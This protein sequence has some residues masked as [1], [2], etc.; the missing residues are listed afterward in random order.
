MKK[1]KKRWIILSTAVTTLGLTAALPLGII[2]FTNSISQI[3][4]V[5]SI[6][7]DD[8]KE[9]IP[10]Q[11]ISQNSNLATKT[12]PLTF[13]GNKITALDWY[14]SKIWDIDMSLY[15]E[16]DNGKTG[17]EA[18]Y[19]KG[20]WQRAWL[21]WDYS[22][23]TDT[24]WIIG[25]GNNANANSK[26][27]L[28]SVNA[29]TGELKETVDLGVTGTVYYVSA[30]ASGNVMCYGTATTTYQ[31]T[32]FLYDVKAKEVRKI[33]GDSKQQADELKDENPSNPN[34]TFNKDYRWS[35]S[36]LIPVSNNVNFVEI[37][38]F[39]TKSSTDDNGAN[40]ASYD[41]YFIMVDDNLNSI[42]RPGWE[43]PKK[44]AS[45]LPGYRNTSVAPQRDYFTLLSGKVATVVYNSVVIVDPS[46][47]N[48]I[49]VFTM[50]EAKWIQ[51]WTIDANENL[52]FKF[53]ADEKIYKIDKTILNS[54][55]NSTLAPQTYL[56]LKG[57][58]QD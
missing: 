56:D 47:L 22:R 5:S 52:Y 31:A 2:N 41:V 13:W 45:G 9:L 37:Y 3:K 54:N 32:A 36:N 12:G 44:I 39:G 53:K 58:S 40:L 7:Q 15:V 27:K 25:Y 21:N 14:G 1:T 50:S 30:L 34:T 23:D 8:S 4:K 6:K 43:K 35:F 26:Q 17:A 20:S 11:N 18:S 51:S 48:N 19:A 10:A 38:A 55:S 16:G 49:K 33:Q 42:K 29:I 57:I 46:N 28:F 24:I